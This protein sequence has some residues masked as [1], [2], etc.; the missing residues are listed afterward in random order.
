M[1]RSF[2]RRVL[3]VEDEP[4]LRSLLAANLT[5]H[6][7]DV[8]TAANALTA[9]RIVKDFDPDVLVVD[10]DLGEGAN[11]LELVG[12]LGRQDSTR[13]YVIL[14]NYSA[15][16]KSIPEVPY[17]SYMNKQDVSETSVLIEEIEGVLRGRVKQVQEDDSA[18]L[19]ASQIDALRMIS[20]G[21]TNQQI[22]DKKKQSVRAV[23]QL[24]T[25]TYQAIGITR[26]SGQS[27]RVVAAQYYK[28]HLRVNR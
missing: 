24:L 27:M 2:V 4:L 13:G 8:Q 7:F 21:M 15:S 22:A 28:Q 19:T 9:S 12:A 6:G 23:E 17:I 14:S 25:R 10:I 18:K 11:G 1:S 3:V 5:N 20:E 26:E 16:V